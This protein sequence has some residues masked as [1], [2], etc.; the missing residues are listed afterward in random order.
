MPYKSAS[1]PDIVLAVVQDKGT[2]R[3]FPAS[4]MILV[5]QVRISV[6][7]GLALFRSSTTL[8]P[9]GGKL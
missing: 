6:G 2:E 1:L 3:P 5:I 8:I 7:N 9:L 4:T